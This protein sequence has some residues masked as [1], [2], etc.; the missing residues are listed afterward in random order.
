MISPSERSSERDQTGRDRP[1]VVEIVGLLAALTE[2]QRRILWLRVVN[3]LSAEETAQAVGSTPQAVRIVQ[4]QALNR[5][6][7]QLDK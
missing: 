3:G 6:R 5:L 2:E 1:P 4:H 7:R